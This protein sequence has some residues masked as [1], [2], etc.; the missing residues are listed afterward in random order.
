MNKEERRGEI[1]TSLVKIKKS[2]VWSSNSLRKNEKDEKDEKNRSLTSFSN[3][4]NEKDE[5]VFQEEELLPESIEGEYTYDYNILAIDNILMKKF[6]Q[7]K[8]KNLDVY[9]NKLEL[10][11]Q[12]ILERQTL[13][14]RKSSRR[15]I[16]KYEEDI[17]KYE[18]NIERDEYLKKTE[19]LIKSYKKLGTISTIVSFKKNNREE[20]A[21]PED[22]KSQMVRHRIIS[23]YLEHARKYIGINLIRTY[24]NS[25][26]CPACGAKYNDIEL[27][28]DDSGSM[29]CPICN[30]EKVLIYKNPF[31]SDGCRVNNSRNNYEDRANFE[32][33]LMRYQGKQITKP[34]RELYIKLDE[35]FLSKG[36]P[37]SDDYQKMPLMLNGRKE[38]SSRELMFEA[39][40]NINCSG[41]YDDIN[42]ICHVFFGW[43]L[44]DVSH[45]EEEIMRDY[46]ISQRIYE[47]LPNRE[48]RK[49]SL[50][51]QWRLYVLLKR[52]GW[53][54]RSRDFKIP[55]TQNIL[56]YHKMVWKQICNILGW[57]CLF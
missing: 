27:I 11:K 19:D 17:K 14:E 45:L 18:E 20:D 5:N 2:N 50:N 51:S 33:V 9:R 28:E 13:I 7:D 15:K 23:E 34:D 4:V 24:L 42:L 55:M 35:Y 32:K 56:E 30:M 52:R 57:E 10:E 39:L 53:P 8:N 43:K 25:G 44:P 38:K 1:K 6:E 12:K 29:V 21:P 46:D 48:G 54:C 41:Y 36:L 40:S 16:E 37:S 47:Q 22:E 26:S 31:F 3:Y 49:S